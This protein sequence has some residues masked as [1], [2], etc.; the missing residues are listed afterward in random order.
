MIRNQAFVHPHRTSP[1][2]RPPYQTRPR[3]ISRTGIMHSL[4]KATKECSPRVTPESA[5]GPDLP[6]NRVE[7]GVAPA[8]LQ[9]HRAY[10]SV[11]GGSCQHVPQLTSMPDVL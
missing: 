8:V 11:H 2:E 4:K 6:R 10:G 5:H 3:A 9:H 7:G 1:P